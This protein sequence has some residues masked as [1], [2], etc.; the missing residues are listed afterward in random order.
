M[1]RSCLGANL[2]SPPFPDDYRLGF[3]HFLNGLEQAT[4]VSCA[5]EVRANDRGLRV[6]H[7]ILEEVT[8]VQVNAVAK[9]DDLAEV[10]VASYPDLRQFSSDATTL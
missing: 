5:F 7:Q 1:G 10:D 4:S 6:G 3:G 2:G 8:G 9:A